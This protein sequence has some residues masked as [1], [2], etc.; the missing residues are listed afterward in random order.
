MMIEVHSLGGGAPSLFV[1]P[2]EIEVTFIFI[3]R[4]D[5][6][7]VT[8][9]RFSQAAFQIVNIGDQ[10]LDFWLNETK[11]TSDPY[12]KWSRFNNIP[13]KIS[14]GGSPSEIRISLQYLRS[15]AATSKIEDY[16]PDFVGEGTEVD[17][18]S[19]S[20]DGSDGLGPGRFSMNM[21]V[22]ASL[23]DA[24]DISDSRT[25]NLALDVNIGFA[26]PDKSR[27]V[28]SDD[29]VSKGV[30]ANRLFKAIIVLRDEYGFGPAETRNGDE[31]R[32]E[33]I[34]EDNIDLRNYL[35]RKGRNMG[36]I[37]KR[38]VNQAGDTV[39]TIRPD[40]VGTMA[41]AVSVNT[42]PDFLG[43][44]YRRIQNSHAVITV[45]AAQCA[46][47]REAVHSVTDGSDNPQE[48]PIRCVCA[49]GNS[50]D[51][52][53]QR[54]QTSKYG[55]LEISE[56][57]AVMPVGYY[58]EASGGPPDTKE[59]SACLP[60][61]AGT[62]SDSESNDQDCEEC[63]GDTFST[64]GS[65]K[66][67]ECPEFG[68]ECAN[69]L[70]IL[71]NNAWC[72]SCSTELEYQ[73]VFDSNVDPAVVNEAIENSTRF[74][75]ARIA[76]THRIPNLEADTKF[77]PCLV[78]D[79]CFTDKESTS[80]QCRNG[81]N[82][83]SKACAECEKGWARWTITMSMH[84]E[85][86]WPIA[87]NYLTVILLIL[88]TI[89]FVLFAYNR[90][91]LWN[92]FSELHSAVSAWDVLLE[93]SKEKG[94][95]AEL[96]RIKE[97]MPELVDAYNQ[98][99]GTLM[100]KAQSSRRD[101]ESSGRV[102]RQSTL[103]NP[104]NVSESDSE[105]I[106]EARDI[107]ADHR[108]LQH[109]AIS[110]ALLRIFIHWVQTVGVLTMAKLVPYTPVIHFLGFLNEMFS[111][112]PITLKPFTCLADKKA[113]NSGG[114]Y[115]DLTGRVVVHTV[116]CILVIGVIYALALS[117]GGRIREGIG[118]VSSE[119]NELWTSALTVTGVACAV[120]FFPLARTG[121]S[122]FSTEPISFS[123]GHALTY[124]YGMTDKSP[125]YDGGLALSVILFVLC[126]IVYPFFVVRQLWVARNKYLQDKE[127]ERR[128]QEMGRRI[129]RS[130]AVLENEDPQSAQVPK[131]SERI[132][133][134]EI[135]RE[136]AKQPMI[137]YAHA[138]LAAGYVWNPNVSAGEEGAKLL[139]WAR[140]IT[141]EEGST[142]HGGWWAA[143]MYEIVVALRK[144]LML[145]FVVSVPGLIE[146]ATSAYIVMMAFLCAHLTIRPF[147]AGAGAGSGVSDSYLE[148]RRTYD[149][150]H[151]SGSRYSSTL[152]V[153]GALNNF[154]AFSI[155]TLLVTQIAGILMYDSDFVPEHEPPSDLASALQYISILF[156]VFFCGF[157][158]IVA[159]DFSQ[160][161]CRMLCPT[162]RAIYWR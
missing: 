130:T 148:R 10:E 82:E 19:L 42:N 65:S 69:G 43:E 47:G 95:D 86:C 155:T 120:L 79:V 146:Q 55:G 22:V 24:P 93:K 87:A 17:P 137:S 45:T 97:R 145:V 67:H 20:E 2:L 83:D 1:V 77:H 110:V 63:R 13:E 80:I 112:V 18:P 25:I 49:K 153:S 125:N 29:D 158:S 118:L 139:D 109:P 34:P 154:E 78:K 39:V 98:F 16:D 75:D 159:L 51:S 66:C 58:T 26:H 21:T 74:Q 40:F 3:C 150:K 124:D 76:G 28:L 91:R 92:I 11:F 160:F 135:S 27:L 123:D 129:R 48:H 9:G 134:G 12:S 102:K 151:G 4:S 106:K 73:Q 105:K 46:T 84:C 62:F 44:N 119:R 101:G 94:R 114:L 15:A 157:I 108:G 152:S 36:T 90:I 149:F 131:K 107:V 38:E 23:P 70:V 53:L 8:P 115:E 127:V 133:E 132:I 71:N 32:I 85:E 116:G 35:D 14:I 88:T 37:L 162:N 104:V 143:Q 59:V 64:P 81:H 138:F 144:L 5:P 122:Y 161:H 117:F 147:G 96:T 111:G 142:R 52:G 31:I 156:N 50:I 33:L 6:E 100:C 141:S 113:A 140:A 99:N 61:P 57:D 41:I 7:P 103:Y 60:C 128:R 72:E 126:G 121:G 54:H 136:L 56:A 89:G 30:V 68:P